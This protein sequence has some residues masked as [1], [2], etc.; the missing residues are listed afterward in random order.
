MTITNFT[1]DEKQMLF[2][3]LYCLT[4]LTGG[5][6][7]QLRFLLVI[8]SFLFITAFLWNTLILVALHKESSLHPPSKLLLRNLATTDLCSGIIAEPL[9]ITY[10]VS[11]LNESWN[12]CRYAFLIFHMAGYILGSVS[13]ITLAAIS[14]DRLLALKLRLRYRQVVTLKRT[15]VTVILSWT[16]ATIGSTTYFWNLQINLWYG[17]GLIS[18][19]LATSVCSYAKI[20]FALRQHQVHANGPVNQVQPSETVSLN[21]AR[22]RKTVF[23]AL[24]VQFSLIVCYLPQGIVEIMLLIGGL[25]PSVLA[26]RLFPV[27]LVLLNSSLNPILYCWKMR[28]VRQAV[29]DTIR[30]LFGWWS[31]FLRYCII[32]TCTI[33]YKLE[34]LR[35]FG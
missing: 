10:F 27:T 15:Y 19:C 16:V 24:W 29:K 35:T 5:I 4:E 26:A 28:E 25:T 22:Y 31:R 6:H 34:F 12:I 17:Y 14:V 1:G 33:L 32:M 18:L 3:D 21:V 23:N 2:E 20:F 8:N 13:L 30:E 11:V 7:H 9:Y